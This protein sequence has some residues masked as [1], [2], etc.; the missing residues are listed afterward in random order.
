MASSE[1]SRLI[2]AGGYYLERCLTPQV[3]EFFGSGGRA[4]A[5]IAGFAP[6]KLHTFAPSDLSADV[7]LNMAG[8]GVDVEIHPSPDLIEF[9][10][11]F[12]LSPP[13]ISPIP[14]P[15]AADARVT[16]SRV[17]R[18]GCLEGEMIV[19][20][21]QAVYDPQSG[22]LPSPF[23]A[24]G[25]KADELALVLNEGEL[26]ALG[27]GSDRDS[28]VRA[29]GDQPA[30]VVVKAGPEGALV[31]EAG[32]FVGSV[33]AYQSASV[34][35]I[36]SGDIFSAMFAYAWM[37]KGAA[38]LDA[39]DAASRYTAHYVE[40]RHPSL[41]ASPPTKQP[42]RPGRSRRFVYLAGPFFSAQQIWTLEETHSALLG[43]GIEH[44]SP[45][46]D[47]GWRPDDEVAELDL[48]GLDKA[49]V[50]LALLYDMDPGTLFEIG[51]ACR[52]GKEV[53]VVV[54]D[55]GEHD[56]TML[57]GTGCKIYRDLA[58]AIYSTAWASMT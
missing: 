48:L 2:V 12:P 43:L 53:L 36:G 19:D 35:K 4:A 55:E 24:N 25:S 33:P 40:T 49:E 31:Y 39:A 20:A 21:R 15:R 6:V 17:L 7:T 30:V 26:F 18:F 9:S 11:H 58:T 23:K 37:A 5:A 22:A 16:G 46:H 34:Y 41:P 47:V 54:E 44:F 27:G 28:A 57:R 14:L 38:P 13:R 29:L 52:N 56:L 50:V 1:I 10:Y 45:L 32:V 42:Y 51:Y 8:F 3:E